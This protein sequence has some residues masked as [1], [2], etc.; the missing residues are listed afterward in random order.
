MTDNSSN[1]KWR[2]C[3][4]D[5]Q[6]RILRQKQTEVP[7]TGI[8]VH[9]SE[10]GMY[11]CAGCGQKLFSSSTK[12]N[13]HSGWPSFY[14][15][16]QKDKVTRVEDNALGMRRTEVICSSCGGHLGHL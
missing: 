12:F 5:E 4:T 6:Y 10:D 13:S 3:L 9:H 7:F 1:T 15:V 11:V 16:V 2:E 14:D 8:Y